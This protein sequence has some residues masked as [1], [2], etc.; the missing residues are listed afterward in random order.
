VRITNRRL[1]GFMAIALLAGGV[2]FTFAAKTHAAGE[3][4]ANA[5]KG[6]RKEFG[7]LLESNTKMKRQI[8]AYWEDLGLTFR[9]V[10]EPWSAV[11]V[12]WCVK[13]A[14]ATKDEFKF[15]AQH[16]VFVYAAIKNRNNS[17]AAFRGH[18]INAYAP[19]VGDIIQNNRNG[20][21]YD[22]DYASKHASYFSH[23]AI[24]V[25]KTTNAAGKPV[26]LTVGGNEDDKIGTKAVPLDT[27]GKIIQRSASPFICVI[28]NRKY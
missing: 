24:V 6:Q 26:V 23:S 15:S 3:S 5:A 2:Q 22:F 4:T 14:G 10:R 1:G 7:G 21:K 27:Q 12:S 8:R 9:N 18:P 28:E 17:N 11:F 19:Q 25:E 20:N 13:Q 16:S